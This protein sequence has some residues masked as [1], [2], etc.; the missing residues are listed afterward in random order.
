L[1]EYAALD[2]RVLLSRLG[3]L[4][5]H[6]AG[7]SQKGAWGTVGPGREKFF[8]KAGPQASKL[9][10]R[11]QVTCH[12]LSQ[13]FGNVHSATARGGPAPLLSKLRTM[14]CVCVCVCVCVY[15]C[16]CLFVCVYVRVCVRA[17][18]QKTDNCKVP[19]KSSLL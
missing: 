8:W 16:V 11:D 4:S 3:T 15:V 1:L 17:C 19:E 12:K 6:A 13:H 10:P 14:A 2:A 9:L 18:V 7:A 5:A